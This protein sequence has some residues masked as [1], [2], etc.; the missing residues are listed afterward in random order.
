MQNGPPPKSGRPV[1]F[2]YESRWMETLGVQ[3]AYEIFS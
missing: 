1:V 3:L 2:V